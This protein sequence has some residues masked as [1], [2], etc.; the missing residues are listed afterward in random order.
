MLEKQ[1]WAMEVT[2]SNQHPNGMNHLVWKQ[3]FQS[4]YE[5]PRPG[6]LLNTPIGCC[7]AV[8]AHC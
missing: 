2:I 6:T 3:E 8:L 7:A 4:E 5:K 1:C